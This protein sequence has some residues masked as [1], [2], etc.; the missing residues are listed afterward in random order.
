M[1]AFCLGDTGFT[2]P[3]IGKALAASRGEQLVVALGVPDINSRAAVVLEVELREI[4]VPVGLAAVLVRAEHLALE[5]P[6]HVFEVLVWT[7]LSPSWR[8]YSPVE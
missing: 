2:N 1:R 4:V 8:T 7:T 3:P 6:E 5:H